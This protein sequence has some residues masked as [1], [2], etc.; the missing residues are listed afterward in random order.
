MRP[1]GTEESSCGR[2]GNEGSLRNILTGTHFG[3]IN[4]RLC[5]P[6]CSHQRCPYNRRLSASSPPVL[7]QPP[8]GGL[9]LQSSSLTNTF[10]PIFASSLRSVVFSQF[11]AGQETGGPY[12]HPICWEGAAA[13]GGQSQVRLKRTVTMLAALAF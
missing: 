12:L 2:D 3:V 11:L 6:I 1:R 10:S 8:G 4:Q 7:S 9:P 5:P 13:R